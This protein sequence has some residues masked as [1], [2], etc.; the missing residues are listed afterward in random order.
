MPRDSL[1]CLPLDEDIDH[2]NG[3]RVVVKVD[4]DTRRP[5]AWTAAVRE[6]LAPYIAEP[7]NE[8]SR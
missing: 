4:P 2:A 1:R 6:R 5:R 8:P 3:S 7:P